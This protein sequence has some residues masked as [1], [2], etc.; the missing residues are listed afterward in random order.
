MAIA[1]YAGFWTKICVGATL[2][3]TNLFIWTYPDTGLTGE[4]VVE[5]VAKLV[6]DVMELEESVV[7]DVDEV[8]V[9]KL[10]VGI[11]PV[12]GK[13]CAFARCSTGTV[14]S[15]ATKN[16]TIAM[17]VPIFLNMIFSHF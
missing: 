8:L 10:V 4:V 13:I 12:Y 15:S 3:T 11:V 17:R 5:D 2:V 1:A 6:E 9:G 7:V 14:T 16:A